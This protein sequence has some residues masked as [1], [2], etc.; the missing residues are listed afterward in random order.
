VG[1]RREPGVAIS[2]YIPL[3]LYRRLSDYSR[4]NDVSISSV[5][6]MALEEFL[7]RER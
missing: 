6:R 1:R 5:V 4:E 2:A 7:K 3:S